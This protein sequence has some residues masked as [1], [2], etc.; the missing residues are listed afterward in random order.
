MAFQ[1]QF[2]KA[3]VEKVYVFEKLIREQFPFIIE[4]IYSDPDLAINYPPETTTEEDLAALTTYVEQYVDPAAY[5]ELKDTRIYPAMFREVSSTAPVVAATFLSAGMSSIDESVGIMN[6]FKTIFEYKISDLSLANTLPTSASLKFELYDDTRKILLDTHDIDL[7]SV[8]ADLK[9][10]SASNP[11]ET[12]PGTVFKSFMIE[13][14]RN[15]RTNYDCIWYVRVCFSESL[16][17]T[18]TM[19]SMQALYYDVY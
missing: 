7:T 2:V 9:A 16:P 11:T 8:I 12:G 17:L 1:I 10:K 14:L 19:H 15:Y 6:A 4:V 3:G 18:A 13:G 5:L